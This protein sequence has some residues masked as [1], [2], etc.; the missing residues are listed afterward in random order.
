M[1][2]SRIAFTITSI[3]SFTLILIGIFIYLKW[4]PPLSF[5]TI[6]LSDQLIV[7]FSGTICILAGILLWIF[8]AFYIIKKELKAPTQGGKK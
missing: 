5:L 4:I 8:I 3:I 7:L 6:F 1:N 2:R